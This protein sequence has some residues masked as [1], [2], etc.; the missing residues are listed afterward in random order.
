MDIIVRVL[1]PVLMLVMPLVLG[2]YLARRLK[3]RRAIRYAASF[4][5]GIFGFVGGCF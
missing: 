4:C 3:G 5:S 2:V 1:N